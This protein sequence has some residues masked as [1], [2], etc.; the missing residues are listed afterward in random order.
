MAAPTVWF[1]YSIVIKYLVF[2]NYLATVINTHDSKEGILYYILR[3]Y[4]IL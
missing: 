4:N 3:L 2:L 1:D